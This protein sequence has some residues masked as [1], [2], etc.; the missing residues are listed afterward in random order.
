MRVHPLT[1]GL[2]SFTTQPQEYK[3]Q[4]SP[5]YPDVLYSPTLHV[6]E[7]IIPFNYRK[8]EDGTAEVLEWSLSTSLSMWKDWK[9]IKVNIHYSSS[10]RSRPPSECVR[11]SSHA[12]KDPERTSNHAGNLAVGEGCMHSSL[13]YSRM[14]HFS[15]TQRN[16]LLPIIFMVLNGNGVH[17]TEIQIL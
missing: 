2:R 17:Y 12:W 6:K 7:I 10:S 9:E 14:Y 15:T 3:N 8:G 5:K 1:H 11:N 16:M 4:T 13:S